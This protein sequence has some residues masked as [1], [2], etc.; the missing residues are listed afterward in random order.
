MSNFSQPGNIFIS[1]YKRLSSYLAEELRELGYETEHITSTGIGLKGTL[2]DCMLLNMKLRTASQVYYEVGRFVADDPEAMYDAAYVLEWEEWLHADGYVSISSFV[3]HP[4][5]NNPMYANTKLKDAVVDRIRAKTNRRP[6]TGPLLNKA[7][8][9]LYWTD[10]EGIIYLDTSGETLAKHGYRLYPGKAPMLESLAAATILASRWDKES[11][12]I[13]PMCGSGT[14]AIE[15]ALIATNRRPGLLRRNYA[16][17]H[18]KGFD[19]TAYMEA[20]LDLEDEVKEVPGLFI[21]AS[22]HNREAIRLARMNAEKAGVDDYIQI[23]QFD[24]RRTKLPQPGAG[25]VVFL[26]PEYGERLGELDDLVI[27]YKAIGDFLKQEC[28]GYIGYVFTGNL[29]LAKKIGLATK[30][31]TEF[32]NGRIDSRLLEFELY[33][34]TL[35]EKLRVNPPPAEITDAPEED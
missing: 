25:G 12:F 9:Y 23:D 13:N 34:G 26:N 6:D 10:T 17:M 19:K 21:H 14:L 3:Q 1:C 11:P 35:T 33:S 28:T 16:F 24:F 15:A 4:S 8:V 31:K 20:V 5:I 30:K 7:V 29:D 18:L 27:M 22:D 2:N 32:F